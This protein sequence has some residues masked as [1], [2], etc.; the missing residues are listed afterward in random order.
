MVP[1]YV[2]SLLQDPDIAS[3]SY[4]EEGYNKSVKGKPIPGQVLKA[5]E[6]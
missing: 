4:K 2:Y 3:F 5:S 6:C 1:E